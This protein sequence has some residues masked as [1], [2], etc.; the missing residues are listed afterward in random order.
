MTPAETEIQ[1]LHLREGGDPL[2]P[3]LDL[4]ELR[5]Q[6]LPHVRFPNGVTGYITTTYEDFRTALGDPRLHAKRFVGE[7]APA[8]LSVEVPDMPG[9]IP[10]M[11]GPDHLRVRRLAAADFSVRAIERLRGYI[12]AVVDTYLDAMAAM[13]PPVD[14]IEAFALPVPSEVIGH[15]LGVPPE[16]AEEFQ[17]AANETIG[18]RKEGLDDPDAAARAVARLHDILGEVIVAKRAELAD[19][20]ISRLTQVGEPPLDDGEIKGLCTNLLLAGHD[21]TAANT[22]MAVVYLLE[23]PHQM[24][25]F[26]AQPDRIPDSV[27]EI[28][29]FNNIVSDSGAAIPRLVTEDMEF[30]G[31]HLVKGDWLLPS[32]ATANTDPTICPYSGTFDITRDPGQHVSF[33][34]GP[35]T[36]LGQHLARAEMQVMLAGLF[37]RFPT[38]QLVSSPADL[39]WNSEAF[40]YR[41]A[42]LPV[43]W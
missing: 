18:G 15:I 9:F 3:R 19:D 12:R 35:H 43:T 27:E 2:S 13:T 7:P 22:S 37:E 6:R 10:G 29:R 41:M 26:R 16:H 25:I 42:A 24:E 8:R 11:N 14:L 32:V 23:N 34:F 28:I 38:L 5:L 39:R 40:V 30:A 17:T 20:L 31:H 33:G 4:Q 1:E 21:T 36:C